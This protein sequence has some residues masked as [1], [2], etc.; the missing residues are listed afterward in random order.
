MPTTQAAIAELYESGVSVSAI[1]RRLDL[2]PTT[3]S[4]HLE[5]LARGP[6]THVSGAPAPPEAAVCDVPTRHQVASLLAAGVARAEIARRLGISK[7]TVSYHARRLGERIDERCARRYDWE[8]VQRYYDA[9]HSVRD[10]MRA[11][12]FSAASWFEAVNR[13]ALVARPSATPISELLVAGRQRGRFNVKTRLV[14]EGLKRNACEECGLVDWRGRPLTLALHHVNG[15]RHDNRLE[16]LMLLCPNCHSQ[17]ENYA[18]RNG[19]RRE[20]LV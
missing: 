17:T 16:N 18:G 7:A 5:R 19:H 20:Q 6:T 13:G 14:K 9:G 2:A 3:V 10:C 4:Y 15:E 1:A 12:G 11:F 8:A